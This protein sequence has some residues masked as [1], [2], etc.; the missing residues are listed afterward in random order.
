MNTS[1]IT[2]AT[3]E[4]WARRLAEWLPR[5]A[6]VALLLIVGTVAAVGARRLVRWLVRRSGLEA[7]AE[8]LGTSRVLYAI[9]LKKGV[10]GVLGDATLIGVVLMTLSI[11]AELLGLPIVADAAQALTA[12]LPRALVAAAILALGVFVADMARNMI[13]SVSERSGA[14]ESPRLVSQIAYWAIVSIAATATADQLGV[15]TEIVRSLIVVAAGCALAAAGLSLALGSRAVVGHMSPAT[16]SS[17]SAR[18][19]TSCASARCRARSFG[20]PPRRCWCGHQTAPT[21]SRLAVCWMGRW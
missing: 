16:T 13:A 14:L 6:A 1:S 17:L 19:A 9:G 10:A 20:S 15:Q 5:L 18:S 3:A 11:A 7:L 2:A 12:F 21:R 8:R 4:L